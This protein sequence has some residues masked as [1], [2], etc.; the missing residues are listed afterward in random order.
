MTSSFVRSRSRNIFSRMENS[1]HCGERSSLYNLAR[2]RERLGPAGARTAQVMAQERACMRSS[3]ARA[4]V[5]ET[6]W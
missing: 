1:G 4:G 2:V 3:S 5:K 6:E